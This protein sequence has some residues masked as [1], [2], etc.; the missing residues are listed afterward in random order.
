MCSGMKVDIE[1]T[2]PAS[3]SLNG[4][5]AGAGAGAGSYSLAR[6]L[7]VKQKAWAHSLFPSVSSVPLSCGRWADSMVNLRIWVL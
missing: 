7:I 1:S 4:A 3:S 2:C 5:G 6:P